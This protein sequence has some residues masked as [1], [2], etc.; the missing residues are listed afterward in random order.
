MAGQGVSQE[1]VPNEASRSGGS[2]FRIG[3][4]LG[5]GLGAGLAMLLTPTTGE[6]TRRRA[7]EQA[8]DLWRRRDELAEE[9]RERARD[10][11]GKITDAARERGLLAEEREEAPLDRVRS[12]LSQVRERVSEALEEGR[13]AGREAE[14]E[15]RARF[16]EMTRQRPEEG[17]PNPEEQTTE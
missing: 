13:E 14:R 11:A 16:E 4:L 5:A 3:F 9:A 10:T 7:A 8:S 2:G 15:T 12:A 6:E 1:P 17:P